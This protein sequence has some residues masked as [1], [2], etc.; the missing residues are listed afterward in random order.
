MKENYKSKDIVSLLS[1]RFS[2]SRQYT[3]AT[4]VG[5][6]TGTNQTRRIDFCVMNH[7]VSN[8]FAI[9]GIE[10]KISKNDLMSEI[11]QPEKHNIFF[12]NLNY[13]SLACPHYILDKKTIEIIPYHWGIYIVKDNVL[14]VKRKPIP[15][16]DKKIEKINKS[17]MASFLRRASNPV[18]TDITEKLS[19]EYFRGYEKGREQE[20]NLSNINKTREQ[21]QIECL[22]ELMQTLNTTDYHD[23]EDAIPILKIINETDT[24][25]MENY[26]ENSIDN[27]SKI[28][29]LLKEVNKY[30]GN[31]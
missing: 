24:F 16:H 20:R 19:Q 1:K 10:I 15:L 11:K 5:D 29:N 12:E 6:S 22:K 23:I 26:I 3:F 9:E 31:K 2:D 8:D 25:L 17:F 21:K 27:L 30:D 7:Y 14:R 4:E 28:N 18:K 13:F